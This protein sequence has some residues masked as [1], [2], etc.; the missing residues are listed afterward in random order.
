MKRNHQIPGLTLNDHYFT[1]PLDHSKP[2]GE[3]IEVYAREV[4]PVDDPE[5][6]K[7][8]I[9]V[10]LQGGP[11]FEA[12]RPTAKSG[13]IKCA[14]DRGYRVLLLDQR[15][16]G[17]STIQ[18][19]QTLARIGEP[20]EQAKHMKHFRADSI[21]RDLEL[22]RVSLL[23]EEGRWSLLGQSFGGFCI[24]H[25]LSAF[26]TH[27]DAVFITGGLP[28][29]SAKA[30]DIYRKTYQRCIEKNQDYYRRYPEDKERIRQIVRFIHENEVPLM[31]GSILTVR[32]FQ[33]FGLGFGMSG[34]Y[35]PLHYLVENA[36]V[37]GEKGQELSYPFICG[38]QN[39]QAFDRNPMYAFLHEAIYCQGFASRWAAHRVHEEFPEFDIQGVL[40]H[41]EDF[42]FTGE[43]VYP[44]MFKDYKMLQPLSEM[45]EL[46]AQD[47]EWPRL[48]NPDVLAK[49]TV[50]C[51]AALYEEDM[52]VD[53]D[54]SK[55]TAKA[56]QGLRVWVT[57]EYEHNG[58]R[59]DGETVLGRLIDMVAGTV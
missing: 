49:N 44:W 24:T 38:V 57:N 40:D 11:G 41:Q 55:E 25:Y 56:I 43:M 39:S 19:H 18:N 34:G 51:A 8:P 20:I 28:P 58:V 1:V 36:F 32:R 5:G 17:R 37:Q 2:D 52:Y 22:M 29:L 31:D 6:G 54:Y 46:L 3:S 33:Q 10:Y 30:E 26:P 45:A 47:T 9:L 7:R 50:P 14:L 4:Y 15:G 23:G 13:W 21:V 35:E 16:T 48:Y 12:A 59:A 27:L 53:R 42:F